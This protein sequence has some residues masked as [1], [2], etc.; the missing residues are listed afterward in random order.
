M[1]LPCIKS[2]SRVGFINAYFFVNGKSAKYNNTPPTITAI[3]SPAP[4]VS[5]LNQYGSLKSPAKINITGTINIFASTGGK[6][7]KYI[8]LKI[9]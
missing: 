9:C 6:T 2:E 7:P 1:R 5:A 3:A 8:P 4:T